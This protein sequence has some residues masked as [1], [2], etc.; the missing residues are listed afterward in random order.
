[1]AVK[2][3][4]YAD[5]SAT[6][7]G[8]A[9]GWGSVVLIDG[10]LHKELAG[11]LESATNNDAEL[12]AAI[13]GLDYALE[14]LSLLQNSFP[15]ETEVTLISDSEIILNWANGSYK[16]KQV[17]KLPLYDHLRRL[18]KKMNVKTQWVKGH[19]GD[20]WNERCDKLAGN[21]RKGIINKGIDKPVSKADTRIGI[22]KTAVVCLWYGDELKVVDLENN[23]VE[24]YDRSIH[25]KR[26][27]AFEIREEKSR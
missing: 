16:F 8:N 14:Y 12:V 26:G 1:M 13:K 4:C 18:V 10:I 24:N 23:V 21:A 27:S 20:L 19:S 25:G 15:I 7:A 3:D 2:I 6:T 5:G 9:G 17:D 11:H 22:K